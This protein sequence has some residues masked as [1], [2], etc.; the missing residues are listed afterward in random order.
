[1]YSSIIDISACRG[2]REFMLSFRI[3]AE[4]EYEDKHYFK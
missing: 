2:T 4:A 1:M 3:G